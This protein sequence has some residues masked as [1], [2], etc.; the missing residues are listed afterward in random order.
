MKVKEPVF[1]IY[2]DL[3]QFTRLIQSS[4]FESTDCIQHL[5]LEQA[6]FCWCDHKKKMWWTWLLRHLRTAVVK[7]KQASSNEKKKLHAS[8]LCLSRAGDT[9]C[10]KETRIAAQKNKPTSCRCWKAQF[11]L[12]VNVSII[13][14]QWLLS[15]MVMTWTSIQK[16]RFSDD[17]WSITYSFPFSFSLIVQMCAHRC[18]HGLA[19]NN[20][21]F[22]GVDLSMW[23]FQLNL[24]S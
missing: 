6:P 15:A 18:F 22:R 12:S 21:N 17:E 23:R 19:S 24:L 14:Y 5:M 20:L 1:V 16:S 9:S 10:I 8:T 3:C 4:S 13:W 11:I 7:R 2:R